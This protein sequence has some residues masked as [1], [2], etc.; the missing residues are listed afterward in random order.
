MQNPTTEKI[1]TKIND[2]EK[3]VEYE[4]HDTGEDNKYTLKMPGL[5]YGKP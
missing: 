1:L 5:G 2:W 3:G 4:N